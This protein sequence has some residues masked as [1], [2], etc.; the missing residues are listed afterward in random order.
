MGL[1]TAAPTGEDGCW[2]GCIAGSVQDVLAGRVQ[3]ILTSVQPHLLDAPDVMG[4]LADLPSPCSHLHVLSPE[5]PWFC[6]DAEE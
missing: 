4:T 1:S 5:N 3:D 6:P 2:L